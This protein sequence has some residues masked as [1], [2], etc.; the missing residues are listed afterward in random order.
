MKEDLSQYAVATFAGGCFWCMEGPFEELEGVKEVLAG[1]TDGHDKNPTYK[2]VSS[3][4]TG[5]TEAVQ[6]FYDPK[7]IDYKK[8]VDVFWRQINPI[9]VDGQFADHGS[10]YRTGIYYHN[11]EQKQIAEAS[12]LKLEASGR[13]DRPI[14]TEIKP[15]ST[16]YPAE[17]YHQDYYKKNA[18]HYNMYKV[19]SGRAGYLDKV[20][21]KGKHYRPWNS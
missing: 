10:Q 17:D 5:H 16:F 4:I 11:D 19:G 20:W 13:Y 9:Q 8:L 14:V 1:Y 7:V 21:G 6:V 12:K 2:A 3:G 15:A 18:M